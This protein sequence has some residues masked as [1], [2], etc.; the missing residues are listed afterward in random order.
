MILQGSQRIMM[1][2]GKCSFK[3][4][5]I[6]GVCDYRVV[7]RSFRKMSVLEV[8]QQQELPSYEEAVTNS[9]ATA[10]DADAPADDTT[11]KNQGRF[12]WRV[13]TFSRRVFGINRKKPQPQLPDQPQ[14]RPRKLK[15][16][17]NKNASNSDAVQF[18]TIVLMG[19]VYILIFIGIVA[20]FIAI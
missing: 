2:L 9:A 10:P 4:K 1:I 6:D 13:V 8:V 19:A 17:R 16:K 5:E 14:A 18:I 3:K 20:L 12:G 15:R 11:T 7:V